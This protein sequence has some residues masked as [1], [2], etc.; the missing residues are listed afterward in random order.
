MAQ[1]TMTEEKVL[2]P[3]MEYY[4]HRVY[5]PTTGQ[6]IVAHDLLFRGG[7]PGLSDHEQIFHEGVVPE[8]A[9]EAAAQ[10]RALRAA[11]FERM[12]QLFTAARGKH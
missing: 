11:V 7:V 5:N 1:P 4:I 8:D 10:D 3:A 9:A 2:F 6:T 12:Y